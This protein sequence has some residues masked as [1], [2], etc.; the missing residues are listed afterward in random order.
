[1]RNARRGTWSEGGRSPR[2]WQ[3]ARFV[4]RF[5]EV[6]VLRLLLA[7][8]LVLAAGAS[9]AQ[10]LHA[11]D[12]IAVLTSPQWPAPGATLRAMAVSEQPL[13]AAL[14]LYGPNGERLNSS[15]RRRGGPPYWWY[16][17]A[18]TSSSGFYRACL[19]GHRPCDGALVGAPPRRPRWPA[20]GAW[21]VTRQ[22]DRATENLYAAWIEKLFDDPPQAA[23]SWPALHEVTRQPERNFLYDYLGLGEDGER[24]L[25]LVPDC[26]D[27]PYVLRAYFAWKLGLPFGYSQCSRGSDGQPPR[28]LS[29]RSSREESPADGVAGMQRVVQRVVDVVQSGNGR[30]AADDDR[31]DFYPTCLSLDTL[32][33]GTVYA[34]PY[35]HTLLLVQ[36][37]PQV[38]P[39]G[40][41]LLAVD[42]QPDGTVA[43]KRYWRGNFLFDLDPALGSPGFKHFRP[44]AFELGSMRPLTDRE[45]AAS[46]DYGDVASE[47]YDG[48]EEFYDRVDAVLSPQPLEPA[49]ALRQTIDALDEQMRARLRAVDNG[50]QYAA[51]H[52]GV[53]P[54]PEGAA[55]FETTGAWEDYATPSR[56]LRLLIAL[57]VVQG[58]PA[59]VEAH[60]QRFA[61]PAGRSAAQVRMD[62][63]EMLGAELAARQLSYVRSDGST[64][65]LALGDVLARAAALEMAYNPNDCVELR[66]GAAPGSAEASTC[67]RRAPSAQ[68]AR[69]AAYRPWFHERRRPPR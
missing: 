24:G 1:M 59:K 28:C 15:S 6:R 50:E 18:P 48:V 51:T 3:R 62:L 5:E 56:D 41:L 63:E 53:I 12:R 69:M 68:A 42:A 32:R 45:I 27:L 14:T 16:V 23:P 40:G 7:G 2:G 64:W 17:E 26:A 22:W 20:D 35:S 36:H 34:D 38:P 11:S 33:P 67:R 49:R 21:P 61:M 43:R 60:P 58:F 10:D 54:M 30:A 37:I 25:R 52:R 66:W 47:H 29:W 31:S 57:D 39:D 55:I 19:G 44:V 4:C 65:P 13:D 46:A 9:R 8:L